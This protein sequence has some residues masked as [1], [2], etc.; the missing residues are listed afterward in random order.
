MKEKKDSTHAWL[1]IILL[2]FFWIPLLNII[3]F[4]PASIHF[5]IKSIRKCK[6]HPESFKGHKLAIFSLI[7]SI[8]FFIGANMIMLF[9]K[10][11]NF[12]FRIGWA[13]IS[14]I[15]LIVVFILTK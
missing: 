2:L 9:V 15:I 6:Q 4:L 10:T 12:P 13:V 11:A 8:I 7:T 1:S 14:L 5:A 3:L